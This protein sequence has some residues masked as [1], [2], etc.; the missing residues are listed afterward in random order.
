[1]LAKRLWRFG[2]EEKSLWRRV[3][4][5]NCKLWRRRVLVKEVLYSY[6]M[7]QIIDLDC[8]FCKAEK[9]TLGHPFLHCSWSKDLWLVG[10]AWWGIV[11][12]FSN[13]VNDWLSNW[14]GLYPS[15]KSERVWGLMFSVV[16]WTI[17]ETRNQ[18]VFEGKYMSLEQATDLFVLWLFLL[19]VALLGWCDSF[20]SKARLVWINIVGVPLKVWCSSFFM[21]LR[22]VFGDP[23]YVEEDSVMRRRLDRGRVLMLVPHESLCPKKIKVLMEGDS[24]LV[25][26]HEDPTLV[27]F[28][29][30]TNVLG[31][32]MSWSNS[33]DSSALKMVCKLS[34]FG[35]D[36]EDNVLEEGMDNAQINIKK[37]TIGMNFINKGNDG[38]VNVRKEFLVGER[39]MESDILKSQRVGER[40]N[41]YMGENN[42]KN[43]LKLTNASGD[44][45]K[46]RKANG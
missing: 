17:W 34:S 4:C 12:C 2:R 38:G 8:P 45:S 15:F 33:D 7:T 6:G 22:G 5:S 24:F 25:R 40:K 3:V 30:M 18:L 46:L 36:L 42:K 31:L 9:E 13:V 35:S 19:V 20:I 1:M 26:L 32:K 21:R 37:R 29:W 39:T 44:T 11:G 28:Q 43:S 16:V 23:L 41:Q 14:I 27:D 10:M